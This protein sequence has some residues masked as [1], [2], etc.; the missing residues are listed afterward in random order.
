[1]NPKKLDL[2]IAAGVDEVAFAIITGFVGAASGAGGASVGAMAGA[3][4]GAF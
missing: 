4:T 2:E 1:M 3:G